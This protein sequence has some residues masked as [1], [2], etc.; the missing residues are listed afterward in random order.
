MTLF[1]LPLG[2][3]L[4]LGLLALAALWRGR[5][6]LAGGLLAAALLWSWLWATPVP[7]ALV[8]KAF[9]NPTT[10]ERLEA[11][12]SAQ[13]IVVLAGHVV[14]AAQDARFD[15]ISRTADRV[16]HAARLFRAG[17]A[18][19]VIAS[20]GSVWN[21][22]GERAAAAVMGDFLVELG[23]PRAAVLTETDSRNTRENAVN[24]VAIAKRRGIAHVL[25][26]TSPRHMPRAA[27]AFS[28]AGVAVTQ[29]SFASA[30]KGRGIRLI[31]LLPNIDALVE[32]TYAIREVMA[33]VVYRLR[34]W[35]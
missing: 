33:I 19:V 6:R 18:P 21:V 23:V 20:G 34:G 4:I 9:P 26:V 3:G 24:T 16:W 7:G 1:A 25:L 28:K 5:T 17:K 29:A 31:S 13:A 22:S 11:L 8:T 2:A 14:P 35:A 15:Q 10:A 30:P 27:A 32:N 12:P